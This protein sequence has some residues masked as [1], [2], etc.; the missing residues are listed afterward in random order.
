MFIIFFIFFFHQ[1]SRETLSLIEKDLNRLAP[2]HH[3]VTPVSTLYSSPA[4]TKNNTP[5]L[6]DIHQNKED[7]KSTS[8]KLNVEY[9]K[10]QRSQLLAQILFIYARQNPSLGYRQGMVRTQFQITFVLES[11]QLCLIISLLFF[12]NPLQN[13]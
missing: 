3:I 7:D 2:S 10:E 9:K 6:E 11:F 5:D 8:D 1:K 12:Y 13:E 4:N